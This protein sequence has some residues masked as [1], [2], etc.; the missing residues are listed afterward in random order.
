MK[1]SILFGTLFSAMVIFA[2]C[3][4]K[5]PAADTSILDW[6]PYENGQTFVLSDNHYSTKNFSVNEIVFDHQDGYG[7]NTDCGVCNNDFNF[8]ISAANLN[9]NFRGYGNSYGESPTIENLYINLRY[10]NV[11]EFFDFEVI[12][13]AAPKQA[14]YVARD[15]EQFY[16]KI[17]I[18]KDIGITEIETGTGTLFLQNPEEKPNK[19]DKVMKV[20]AC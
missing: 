11:E 12:I 18:I 4:I 3:D 1:N 19:K 9:I 2:S 17:V 8:S 14:V 7:R 15:S 5:C 20:R 6:F 16:K 13:D 10:N